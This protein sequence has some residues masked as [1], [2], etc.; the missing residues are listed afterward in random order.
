[1]QHA[2]IREARPRVR[3]HIEVGFDLL[4]AARLEIFTG[5]RNFHSETSS[6][7]PVTSS[8]GKTSGARK[9][10]L[11]DGGGILI[12]ETATALRFIPSAARS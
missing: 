4:R 8:P 9:S 1:M 3:E 2:Q 10:G 7:A 6:A 11:S 12:G 5:L